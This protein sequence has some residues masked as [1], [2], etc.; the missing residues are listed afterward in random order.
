M[1]AHKHQTGNVEVFHPCWLQR[2]RRQ[3]E[4]FD[5][6]ELAVI[7][8][9]AHA[10]CMTKTEPASQAEGCYDETRT[11]ADGISYWRNGELHNAQGFA[12]DR[13]GRQEAWLFGHHLLTPD[14]LASEPL[15][16]TGQDADGN[17]NWVDGAGFVRAVSRTTAAGIAETRWFDCDGKPE[18]HWSGGY[19]VMR[20]LLSGETRH[21]F[22]PSATAKPLLHRLDGPAIQDP[23]S[24]VRSLWCVDGARVQGP[25]ELLIR[26]TVRAQQAADHG[27]RIVRLVLTPAEEER[28]RL[29]VLADE[30]GDL[31]A[32]IAIAFPDTYADAVR[33]LG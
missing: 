27:R 26:H 5:R 8:R 9:P 24:P 7:V 3:A 31:A 19:H 12:V 33:D 20:V 11:H 13:E 6:S 30:R 17:V 4:R 14:H 23:L 21:Y 22:Q 28:L 29:T 1:G 25:L 10:P 2:A 18:A 32:D 16:F 15:V